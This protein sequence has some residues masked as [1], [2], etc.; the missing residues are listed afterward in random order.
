M[1]GC[2]T[3]NDP[4]SENKMKIGG[5]IDIIIEVATRIIKRR[6]WKKVESD[7]SLF[8]EVSFPEKKNI[9]RNFFVIN[10]V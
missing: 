5:E 7:I 1:R 4:R 10:D 3:E 8:E 2:I 6:S 9:I